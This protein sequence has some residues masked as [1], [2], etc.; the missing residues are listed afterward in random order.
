[1]NTW[2]REKIFRDTIIQYQEV[3]IILWDGGMLNSQIKS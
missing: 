3:K 2:R 1:M